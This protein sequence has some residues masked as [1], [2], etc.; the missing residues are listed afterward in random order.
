MCTEMP[1]VKK[2]EA[3]LDDGI[4]VFFFFWW[5]V[6][7][8]H[9]LSCERERKGLLSEVDLSTDLTGFV[10]P[11]GV[12]YLPSTHFRLA[13]ARGVGRVELTCERH[14]VWRYS[15]NQTSIQLNTAD[16]L[17]VQ[18]NG[19]GRAACYASVSPAVGAANRSCN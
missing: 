2:R 13:F 11:E 8:L 9:S 1:T 12:S 7:S 5:S 4:D 18:M 15:T 10:W 19:R 6:K 14:V 17:E 16:C 3:E